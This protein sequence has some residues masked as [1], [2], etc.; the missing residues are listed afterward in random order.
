MKKPAVELAGFRFS[1]LRH[2]FHLLNVLF[3]LG[4]R[5]VLRI[6]SLE[7]CEGSIGLCRIALFLY[8]RPLG[9]EGSGCDWGRFRAIY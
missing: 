5:F 4:Y 1:L 7:L 3:Q 2:L 9:S 6:G 8:K